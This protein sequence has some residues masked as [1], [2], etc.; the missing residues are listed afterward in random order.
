MVAL[1]GI[2]TTIAGTGDRNWDSSNGLPATLAVVSNPYGVALVRN[3][4][5]NTL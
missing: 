3:A 5:A 2:I 1:N 4:Q